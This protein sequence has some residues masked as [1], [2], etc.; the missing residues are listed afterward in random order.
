[1]NDTRACTSCG[2]QTPVERLTVR[3]LRLAPGAVTKRYCPK[4]SEKQ[5]QALQAIR[6]RREACG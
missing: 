4:C 6:E 1:M 2:K 5:E 3:I